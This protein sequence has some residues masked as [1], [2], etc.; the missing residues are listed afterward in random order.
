MC[1]ALHSR[2]LKADFDKWQDEDDSDDGDDGGPAEHLLPHDYY[3][4]GMTDMEGNPGT[5]EGPD[6]EPPNLETF[7]CFGFRCNCKSDLCTPRAVPPARLHTLERCAPYVY[8][9]DCII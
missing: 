4:P 1:T 9:L 8:P 7:A 2:W 5:V 3:M 6:D